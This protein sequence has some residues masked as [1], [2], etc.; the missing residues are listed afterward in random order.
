MFIVQNLTCPIDNPIPLSKLISVK[1]RIPENSLPEFELL[2]KSIDARKK[3]NLKWNFTALISENIGGNL[4]EWKKSEPE[5]VEHFVMSSEN[6]FIIGAGPAGLFCALELVEKGFKPDIFDRGKKLE[7]RDKDTERFWKSGHLNT[8]SNSQ[9]GEG[10]AGTFSDGKLTAR[11]KNF[12]SEKVFDY[13]IKFGADPEIKTQSLPHLGTDK[14]RS[15]IK[16]IRNYL[17]ENGCKFHWS[18][19]LNDIYYKKDKLISVKINNINYSPEALILATGNSAGD[20]FKM[21][22]EEKIALESKPFAVGFRIEHQQKFI[23]RAFYGEKTDFSVTGAAVYRLTHKLTNRGVYSFCM[24][25]GG[26]VIAAA[27][28]SGGQV[29]NGMSFSK[30]NNKY[31]N[32]AVVCTADKRDFGSHPLAGIEFQ[33][34]IERKSFL[35]SHPYRAPVNSAG[36]FCSYKTNIKKIHSSYRPGIIKTDLNAVFPAAI[37]K[38]LQKGLMKFESQTEGFVQNGLLIGSETRTSSPVRILRNKKSGASLTVKNLFPVGEGSGYSG[39]II[40]SAADGIRTASA[41]T[42]K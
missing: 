24:C 32:S 35:P 37:T 29:V 4:T 30:R 12:Y 13:L 26:Y 10:G 8:E 23:N 20:T 6:P 14:L 38:A 40:S 15:I 21:L 2:R 41:F 28:E 34:A 11:N 17:L 39:G 27:S 42:L 7:D 5:D 16:N 22:F 31:A 36:K 19:R 25:P 3:N 33:R 9:F 18:N 1:L